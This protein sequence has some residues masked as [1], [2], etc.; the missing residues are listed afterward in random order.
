MKES[1]TYLVT[2]LET[3]HDRIHDMCKNRIYPQFKFPT[4]ARSKHLQFTHALMLYT[5]NIDV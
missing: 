3:S 4:D 1:L 5:L 2:S